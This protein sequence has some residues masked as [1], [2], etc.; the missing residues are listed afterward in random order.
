MKHGQD[1]L[2]ATA[3]GNFGADTPL[4]FSSAD[5]NPFTIS[6]YLWDFDTDFPVQYSYNGAAWTDYESGTSL[7]SAG[8]DVV[9]FRGT[10]G[11]SASSSNP[12][13]FSM[14]GRV[15]AAGNIMSMCGYGELKPYCFTA[16]SSAAHRLRQHLNFL[17]RRL[18]KAAT[19]T[20]SITAH[21]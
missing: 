5:G 3:A 9:Y 16:C 21:R 2:L 17:P 6:L 14:S 13:K 1:L 10:N 20:C 7:W 8:D 15:K 19:A 11:T 4:N 18:L 12:G